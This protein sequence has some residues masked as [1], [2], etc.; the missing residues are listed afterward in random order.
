MLTK[1]D[2][3][4]SLG[5]RVLGSKLKAVRKE[6]SLSQK[7]V[8]ERLRIAVGTYANWE[9]GRREP[10]YADLYNLIRFWGISP[11]FFFDE[12]FASLK[13]HFQNM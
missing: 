6:H 13:V 1:D 7:Q 3:I 5:A 11:D 4:R 2:I 12:T 8:A 9:Q 10:C